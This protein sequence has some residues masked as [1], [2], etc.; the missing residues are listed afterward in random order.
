MKLCELPVQNNPPDGPFRITR[1]SGY[2]HKKEVCFLIFHN[3]KSTV[4][5]EKITGVKAAEEK[6]ARLNQAYNEV[7]NVEQSG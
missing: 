5:L 3:E 7:G 6:A 2:H 1:I 4:R